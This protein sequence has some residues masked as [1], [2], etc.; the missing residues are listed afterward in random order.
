MIVALSSKIQGHL[1][2]LLSDVF[3]V[4]WKAENSQSFSSVLNISF[5]N[6]T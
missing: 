4:L 1:N 3:V 6:E 5:P 2:V